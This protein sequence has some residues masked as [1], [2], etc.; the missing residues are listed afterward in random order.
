MEGQLQAISYVNRRMFSV[1]T[2]NIATAWRELRGRLLWLLTQACREH[3]KYKKR[4]KNYAAR[5]TDNSGSENV[6]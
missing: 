5:N 4:V 3:K 6:D 1:P 2:F